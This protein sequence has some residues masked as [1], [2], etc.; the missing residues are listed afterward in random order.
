MENIYMNK[1][2]KELW[3]LALRDPNTRQ[4]QY[5][6]EKIT[7]EQ[8]CLGVLC[9]VAIAAGVPVKTKMHPDLLFVLFDDYGYSLPGSVT[10]WAELNNMNEQKVTIDG[11]IATLADHNDSHKTFLQIA[12]AIEEQL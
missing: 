7:G 2:A 10:K 5:A 4:G 6:L 11:K 8:C 12:D 3:L 1:E 9:R